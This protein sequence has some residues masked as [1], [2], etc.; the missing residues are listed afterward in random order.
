M[1]QILVVDDEPEMLEILCESLKVA[2][3][4]PVGVEDGVEAVLAVL[5]QPWD[6]ILMDIR[7]PRLDGINAMRIIHEIYPA[8]PVI[9]FTG[10]AGRGEMTQAAKF[11]AYTS[12]LKP[13]SLTRLMEEIRTALGENGEI[14][15]G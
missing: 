15:K 1:T 9:T 4:A 12:L 5:K 14:K 8:V 2:G 11:G 10:Q 3:Y 7:M 6:L 13:V